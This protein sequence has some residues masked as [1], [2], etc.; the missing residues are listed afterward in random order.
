MVLPVA[1]LVAMS[2][3]YSQVFT[4]R[5]ALLHTGT[6]AAT[7]MSAKVFP[8][9]SPSQRIVVA[10]LTAGSP[11]DPKYGRIARLRSTQNRY[12]A[13]PVI[14]LMV[15]PTIIRWHS[16]PGTTGSSV[17]LCVWWA[18]Q[19]GT[20]THSTP[21]RDVRTWR[22]AVSAI[23]PIGIMWLST[24]GADKTIGQ[25]AR[26]IRDSFSPA[27]L[28]S[29]EVQEIVSERCVTCHSE[30]PAWAGRLTATHALRPGDRSTDCANPGLHLFAIRCHSGHAA[31]QLD[32]YDNTG[33]SYN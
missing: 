19:F 26:E 8:I 22:G 20:S 14:F 24:F 30:G 5:A 18:K 27:T 15:L 4:G 2:S 16:Q 10:D 11:L 13:W 31:S 28:C 9:K 29:K 12:P 21:G 7:I 1:L 32:Q 33:E 6:H 17:R 23:I 25:H 3:S